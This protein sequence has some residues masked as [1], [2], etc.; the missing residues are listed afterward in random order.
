MLQPG[1]VAMRTG[2]TFIFV[3]DIEGFD[4]NIA[5]A[6]YSANCNNARSPMAGRESITD[7]RLTWYRKKA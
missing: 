1:D 6:S 7:S 2:H 3:G 5:S 4:S